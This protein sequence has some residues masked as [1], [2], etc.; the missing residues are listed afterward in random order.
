MVRVYVASSLS[1]L[2]SLVVSDGV[3]PAPFIGHAVTDALREAYPDGGDE[4]WEYAASSAAAQ[5]SIGLLSEDQARR[6]VVALDASSVVPFESDDPTTV[7]VGDVVPLRQIGAVLVDDVGA[8][9]DVGAAAL[10]WSAAQ[11]G[12]AE[13]VTAV[14]RCVDHELGWYATQEIGDLLD[15]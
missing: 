2:R 14:E 5:E 7:E 13:A 1:R 15:G 11:Q 8:S 4:E 10:A 3:G 6:V 12:D 9:D